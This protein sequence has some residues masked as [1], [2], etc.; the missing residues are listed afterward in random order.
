MTFRQQEIG[1]IPCRKGKPRKLDKPVSLRTNLCVAN[2]ILSCVYFVA[3]FL[4][5]SWQLFWIKA[6]RYYVMYFCYHI[7]NYNN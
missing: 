3:T 1:P 7:L 6:N 2:S 5:L 4:K